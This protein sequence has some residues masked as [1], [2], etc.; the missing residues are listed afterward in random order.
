M[1]A[2][3]PTKDSGMQAPVVRAREFNIEDLTP[4]TAD[5]FV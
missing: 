3:A 5:Q 2:T 4:A 1:W